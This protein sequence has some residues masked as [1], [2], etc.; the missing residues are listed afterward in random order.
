MVVER[1]SLDPEVE[2]RLR[3]AATLGSRLVVDLTLDDIDDL[4][5]C[6]AAE[7][8][9]CDDARVRRVFDGLFDRL[10]KLE[11]R[12]TNE[13]PPA[14]VPV[15]VGRSFTAKQGQYLAFIHY[16]TKI[17]GVP[18]AEADLQRFFK[19]SPPAVHAMIVTLERGGLV[20][21]T[22]GKARSLRLRVQR[23]DLPDLE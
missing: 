10:T 7:A 19:V 13:A 23:T 14:P 18:P 3:G 15:E 9:H 22:A 8:N 6:V 16:Y 5:G 20:E 11:D 12:F 2:S 21:R 4:A 1:A 17:H